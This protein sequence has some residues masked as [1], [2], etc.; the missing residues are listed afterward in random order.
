MKNIYA[1][2][3][4]DQTFAQRTIFTGYETE[5]TTPGYALINMGIGGEVVQKNKTV[6]SWHIAINNLTD[7]AYQSHLS[8][9]KYTD[10]N[11][12]NGRTGVFNMGRNIMF[13]INIPL[14]G[15]L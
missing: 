14:S 1:K 3:V 10:T 5:T 4:L 12:I 8:R 9:L 6:L 13:R 15:K 2:I 11:P 7:I